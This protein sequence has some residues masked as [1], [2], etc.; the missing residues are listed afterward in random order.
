MDDIQRDTKKVATDAA[1]VAREAAEKGAARAR[2]AMER[3]GAAASEAADAMNSGYATTIRAAQ[4]YSGKVVEFTLA[5]TNAT[6]EL[7]HKLAGVTSPAAMVEIS[8]AHTRKQLETMTEQ[9]KE[10]AELARTMAL[11]SAEPFKAG[12]ARAFS[13]A[14]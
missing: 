11:A 7:A 9:T 13:G 5:N 4:E 3:T 2:E 8:T 10:L 6:L 14:T 1:Q 12:F